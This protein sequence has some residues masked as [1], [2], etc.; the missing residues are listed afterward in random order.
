[1]NALHVA[2]FT[3]KDL[4]EMLH[5]PPPPLQHLSQKLR[6]PAKGWMAHRVL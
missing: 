2:R 6:D 1:M 4:A 5:L 3:P